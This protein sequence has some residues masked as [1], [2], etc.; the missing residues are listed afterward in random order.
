MRCPCRWIWIDWQ[1]AA[2]NTS[3]QAPPLP[4]DCPLGIVNQRW[5]NSL[6]V[7]GQ[8]PHAVPPTWHDRNSNHFWHYPRQN[9]SPGMRV[10]L[11]SLLRSFV[12]T[13]IALNCATHSHTHTLSLTPR[14]APSFIAW[15]LTDFYGH[16]ELLQFSLLSSLMANACPVYYLLLFLFRLTALY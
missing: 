1:L 10:L 15:A 6:A 4:F 14:I 11:E 2:P 3:R 16:P 7:F 13:L 9:G 12:V 8:L 5:I